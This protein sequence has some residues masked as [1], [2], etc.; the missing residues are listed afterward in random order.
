MFATIPTAPFV[1]LAAVAVGGWHPCTPLDGETSRHFQAGLQ[2][3]I[4]NSSETPAVSVHS[5]TALDKGARA[6]LIPRPMHRMVCGLETG[7]SSVRKETRPFGCPFSGCGARY[8]FWGHLKNHCANEHW[9]GL[10][11]RLRRRP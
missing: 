5:P 3:I 4:T 11:A 2:Q 6:A 10:L 9:Y 7:A 1:Y 8:T